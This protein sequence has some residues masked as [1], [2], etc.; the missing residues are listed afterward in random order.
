MFS[1][2]CAV[3]DVQPSHVRLKTPL[4]MIAGFQFANTS[5]EK[6]ESDEHFSHAEN[7]VDDKGSEVLNEVSDVHSVQAC[8]AL[9]ANGRDELKLVSDKHLYQARY[10]LVAVGSGVLNEVNPLC[11]HAWVKLAP[12]ASVPSRASL[13]NDVRAEQECH[14]EKKFEPFL[15]SVVLKLLSD[16]QLYHA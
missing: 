2:D 12:F 3:S 14:A 1:T 10:T 4:K 8:R 5:A 16:V 11:R 7:M 9:V 13:G 6:S 15:M